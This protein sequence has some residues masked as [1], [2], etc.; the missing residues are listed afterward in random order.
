MGDAVIRDDEGDLA[1]VPDEYMGEDA[2][3][4]KRGLR[5][6]FRKLVEQPFETLLLAHGAPLVGNGRSALEAFARGKGGA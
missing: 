6:V 5:R 2:A 1:F 3:E 4:V